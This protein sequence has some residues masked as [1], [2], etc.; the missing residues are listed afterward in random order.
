MNILYI[1]LSMPPAL[2]A[3]N[4]TVVALLGVGHLAEKA[5]TKGEE[6]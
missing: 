1:V 2:L 5:M 4:W 3:L 6:R